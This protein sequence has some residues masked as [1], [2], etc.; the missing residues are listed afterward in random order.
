MSTL[1]IFTIKY[2]KDSNSSAA[3]K[4]QQ[5]TTLLA[6]WE[7]KVKKQIKQSSLNRKV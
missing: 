4:Q 7:K 6:E 2:S 3:I 1:S 5:S